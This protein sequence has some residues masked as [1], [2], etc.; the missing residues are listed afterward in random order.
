VVKGYSGSGTADDP[1]LI[2]TVDDLLDLTRPEVGQ[3]GYYFRQ[4]ADIDISGISTWPTIHFK[5]NYDGNYHSISD[6]DSENIQW[7]FKSIEESQLTKLSIINRGLAGAAKNQCKFLECTANWGFVKDI[8]GCELIFCTA[9]W[10]A[11][12]ATNCKII[13]CKSTECIVVGEINKC[14]IINC[15][16]G[17]FITAKRIIS[18]QVEDCLVSFEKTFSESG[19]IAKS[20]HSSKINRCF[21]T[22]KNTVSL[23]G[24]IAWMMEN[25]SV[26]YC[27]I[28]RIDHGIFDPVSP[29]DYGGN[30]VA[31]NIAIDSTEI[32][33]NKFGI[34]RIATARFKQ[35]LFETTLG[36]DFEN[37]W[38]WDDKN[39]R[40]ALRYA[41][42][43]NLPP[44]AERFAADQPA[45]NAKASIDLLTQQVTANIWL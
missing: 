12:T 43:D 17:Q 20:A 42:A 39:D 11:G 23:V 40:P 18:S 30:S 37:I 32:R 38:I 9:R 29:N 3:K 6:K 16:A 45:E 35:R 13:N 44:S 33:M 27:A 4:T 7:I 8:D 5:G 14:N 15:H 26:T 24:G 34:E 2:Q 25:T 28:G 22:G 19:I 1:L 36:W 41:G 10:L 21:V 31:N